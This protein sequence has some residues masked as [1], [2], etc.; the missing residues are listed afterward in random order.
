VDVCQDRAYVYLG[1]GRRN[2]LLGGGETGSSPQ[3]CVWELAGSRGQ[4]CAEK[5][6]C[7][8]VK[9][10]GV[11]PANV[12]LTV[13]L[14]AGVTDHLIWL[15]LRLVGSPRLSQ[16]RDHSCVVAWADAAPHPKSKTNASQNPFFIIVVP[17]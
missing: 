6:E 8:L 15:L 14:R 3:L 17:S 1:V 4:R 10:G 16:P 12:N 13:I 11:A 9:L 7:D 2:L 5:I